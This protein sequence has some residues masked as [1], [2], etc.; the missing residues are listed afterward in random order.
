MKKNMLLL[1]VL[2][3]SLLILMYFISSTD[4]LI[5]REA[6]DIKRIAVIMNDDKDDEYIN[7][8]KGIER[9]CT[10]Y[11]L[12]LDFININHRGDMK[13]Q[14]DI[15]LKEYR[16]GADAVIIAA[17]D[18][19]IVFD[20]L[21]KETIKLPVVVLGAGA[22][23]DV[24]GISAVYISSDQGVKEV[25]EAICKKIKNEKSSPGNTGRSSKDSAGENTMRPVCLISSKLSLRTV[26]GFAQDIENAFKKEGLDVQA[27]QEDMDKESLEEI[28][29]GFKE[30]PPV[31]F[32][33]DKESFT[34]L[35]YLI[36]ESPELRKKTA[37]IYGV[38][39]TVYILNKVEQEIIDGVVIWN[40]Y[41][42]GYTAVELAIQSLVSGK[43]GEKSLSSYYLDKSVLLS[44]EYTGMLYPID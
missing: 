10:D 30:N 44:E 3:V 26:W 21:E 35:T 32:A 2:Y 25:R 42:E 1:W 36:S 13:D 7:L 43:T 39:A 11:N 29:N 12:E 27:V 37:G 31:L 16:E 40:E 33:M 28:L 9:A 38:G 8:K 15:M 34:N 23:S 22:E 6:P 17:K 14:F 5:S 18:G 24:P 20:K 19:R 4:F 41:E